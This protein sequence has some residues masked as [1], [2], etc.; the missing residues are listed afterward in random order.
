MALSRR[1]GQ[2][3]QGSI[4]PGFVD[5]MTSLLLV[6]MFVL[7]IFMVVQFTLQET[8]TGQETELDELGSELS[9][10]AQALG[11]ER[12]RTQ[13]LQGELGQLNATLDEAEDQAQAQAA[14][15][16][17]LTAERDTL[18][19][20]RDRTADSLRTAE[21]RITDFESQ[22]AA[23]LAERNDARDQVAALEDT[24][25]T[26]VSDRD[27]L[28]TAL[29]QA[30]SE[31]DE[32]AEAARLA[33]ARREAL[34][35][36][37]AD[38]RSQ[39]DAAEQQ[40]A[41]LTGQVAQL[42]ADLTDE[43]KTRLA[44]AAAAQALRDRLKG[45]EDELTAMTLALEEQ[46]KRAEDTLTLLA[47][48]ED[49]GDDLTA[50]LA[51]ALTARDQ[52]QARA[53]S[54]D[55]ELDAARA[56]LADAQ[57]ALAGREAALADALAALTLEEERRAGLEERLDTALEAGSA[58]EALRGDKTALQDSLVA[59]EQRAADNAR[60]ATAAAE[61]L[62]QAQG[63]LA[64]ARGELDAA[65]T[66][67]A[68][69]VEDLETRLAEALARAAAAETGQM[70]RDAV[71]KQLAAA[72][73]ARLKAE[74]VAE[75]RLSE[76]EQRETLL[77]EAQ[78]KLAE[79]EA[80]SAESQ[81]RRALLNQQV[82]ALRSQLGSLQALLGEAQARDEAAK[83]E[84][85]NLGRDLNTALA[86]AAA[87]QRRRADLE[88]AERKRLE[89]ERKQLAAQQTDLENYRSDFFGRLRQVLSD[90][91]GVRIVGDRFV[92]SSEV[93]FGQG[94]ADLSEEGRQQIAQIADLIREIASDIP[95]GID[96][97]LRVDGHTDNVPFVGNARYA[98]NWELS[99]AR[100]LSVVRYMTDFLGLPPERLSANG[101][102]QYQP[103][104]EGDSPE[105]RAMNRRIELKLTER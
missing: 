74:Q 92:F 45:A 86:R 93:L 57:A 89:E 39:N 84:M 9:A 15:L 65:R 101:F 24:R 103:I 54:L 11:L 30:R 12:D 78:A 7:T 97:I 44:E 35:A 48:A 10:L 67:A 90:R 46:R 100:A 31:I 64:A 59:A 70:D 91:D 23:L 13:Q 77:K 38:L 26:L 58:A 16:V 41:A 63:D 69:Q 105:A 104:A 94:Q 87:E 71:Q 99:Q 14:A 21:A 27:A 22:V 33:A 95:D 50:R 75:D 73:A 6:L 56:D 5:A 19:A 66:R 81:R 25:D 98:D 72:L 62:A 43:E 55:S 18:A 36:L 17:A 61:K 20:D 40:T 76:A 102:G 37:V 83:V 3:F 34:E 42:Q 53:A 2:R 49:A 60:A 68:A 96:W 8:I 85:A 4:W 29:A 88:A 80:D 1:T 28:Q 52:G 79:S 32:G 82:A 51:A 47:A